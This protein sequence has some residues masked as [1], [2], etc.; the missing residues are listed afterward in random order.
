MQKDLQRV[1]S[2]KK[3]S[4]LTAGGA[5]AASPSASSTPKNHPP[6]LFPNKNNSKPPRR[7]E[8]SSSLSTAQNLGLGVAFLLVVAVL[9]YLSES[10]GIVLEDVASSLSGITSNPNN[11]DVA[12]IS[13][14]TQAP[15]KIAYAVSLIQCGDGKQNAAE[16]LTEA[17]LVL[18]H[19]IHHISI[20]NPESQSKYDYKLYA[21]VHRQA[22]SCSQPLRDAG[23]D[24]RIVDPPIQVQDIQ[25][26]YLRKSIHK[27]VCCGADEFIKLHAFALPEPISVH[28]D[29]D[30]ILLKP[31]DDLFD[32]ILFDKNSLQGKAARQ[33]LSKQLDPTWYARNTTPTTSS[34]TSSKQSPHTLPDTI[35]ALWVRD[36]FSTFPGR[37]SPYQAGFIVA[38]RKPQVIEDC[39][40]V[41][42]THNYTEGFGRDNGW[43]SK[44]YGGFIG[45]RAMQGLL[46]YYYDVVNP[47]RHVELHPCRYN[48]QGT[49]FL[50][51]KQQCKMGPLRDDQDCP[52]C[53]HTSWSDVSSIHYTSCRKPWNCVAEGIPG[54]RTKGA[55]FGNALDTHSVDTDHCLQA[56]KIWHAHR[57]DLEA[58][59]SQRA[60]KYEIQNWGSFQHTYFLGHC[61]DEKKYIR[62]KL[63]QDTQTQVYDD[64]Y[65]ADYN[66]PETKYLP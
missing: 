46:A 33:R 38:R 27:E 62:M 4:V 65:Q 29:M 57:A 26:D 2:R 6:S 49:H 17:A 31:M 18:R 59:I 56:A 39:A 41:I 5:T 45:A 55:K 16:G 20:H 36:W 63:L 35:D 61:A 48:H 15:I 1:Q 21:L 60:A 42:T 24:I 64:I 3:T 23:Y 44:G 30:F 14:L 37:H 13:T 10:P 12:T 9:L 25:S 22:E 54:G 47:G 43:G 40:N 32:V 34:T 19:S 28:V 7:T 66:E 53:R 8:S 58:R 50:A 52:D 51:K 11:N